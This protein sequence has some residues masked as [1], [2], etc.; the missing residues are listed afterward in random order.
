MPERALGDQQWGPRCRKRLPPAES[1]IHS[2]SAVPQGAHQRLP[3]PSNAPTQG[4]AS[5]FARGLRLQAVAGADILQ[6]WEL[7]AGRGEGGGDEEERE[8]EA[9]RDLP[10]RGRR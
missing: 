2:G 9:L 7:P 8:K 3:S 1:G 4:K 5:G 10:S 6:G